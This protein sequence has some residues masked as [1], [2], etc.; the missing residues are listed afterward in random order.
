MLSRLSIRA[1]L[2]GGFG[3]VILLLCAVSLTSLFA[4][5][6]LR[7]SN[8]NLSRN[9]LPSV[10]S[11]GAYTAALVQIRQTEGALQ[12]FTDPAERAS[13]MPRLQPL[14]R[15][16]QSAWDTYAPLMGE[17]EE[18]RLAEEV[19]AR[20]DV[21]MPKHREAI[22]LLAANE[23]EAA[24][25]V[26]VGMV[27]EYQ[28]LLAAV[29]RLSQFNA[30][31]ADTEARAADAMAQQVLW[32]TMAVMV[33][34]IV[35][36]VLIAFAIGRSIARRIGHLSAAMGQLARR[37]YG[38]TLVETTDQDEIGILAR[39]I[40]TCREGLKEAD[41]MAER[42]RETETKAAARA[43]RIDSLV[44]EFD[45]EASDALRTVAAAATELD[46]TAKSMAETADGSTS[47]AVAVAAA[48]EQASTNIQTVAAS[49][50]ELAASI[51]EVARQVRD[52]AVITGRAAD[53]AR[54]TDGT[55]RGLADAANRIGDVV[56]LIND[57]A[58]QTNLLALNATIEAAR[59]GEAGKGF[60]V[61]ASEVKTLANE[62][63]KA[64]ETIADQ[65]A[66]MQ[67]ATSEVV[68]A[69]NSITMAIGRINEM[70]T[71]I[72][73]AVEEQGAATSEITRSVA[74]V[75]AGTRQVSEHVSG[76]RSDAE[77]TRQDAQRSSAAIDAQEA[78]MQTLQA[79]VGAF[80]ATVKA[81]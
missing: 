31:Q 7:R 56:R 43:T 36:A 81:A 57:I 46:A 17:G 42:Q 22:R 28:A 50:E 60:A 21:Y 10:R 3:V 55:V 79:E 4:E 15:A 11:L 52:T 69:I 45:S 75:A 77:R 20:Q 63:R 66:G 16:L 5:A 39:A 29:E 26:L 19:R 24:L 33:A 23:D 62:T 53:A 38:F 40:D 13:R 54:E 47:Q 72:A 44:A 2:F 8:D 78:T 80:L 30:G 58:G 67:R 27:G 70:T 59:A 74:D 61:V 65:V 41:A 37:D 51:A 64:T 6:Q 12:L 32:I 49:A 68:T 9:W 76:L 73:A 1:K 71:A 34:A 18:R 48:T 14:Y 25:R 35:V